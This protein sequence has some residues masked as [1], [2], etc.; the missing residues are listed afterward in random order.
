M[1]VVIQFPR[2]KVTEAEKVIDT[3]VFHLYN[4]SQHRRET[5]M[6]EIV[7]SRINMENDTE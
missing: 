1:G 6:N 3:S 2:K 4:T 5:N 7:S